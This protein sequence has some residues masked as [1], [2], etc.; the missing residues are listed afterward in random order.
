MDAIDE[1]GRSRPGLKSEH[2]RLADRLES[3]M[4]GMS[5]SRLSQI[6]GV[7]EGTVRNILSGTMPRIDN[8]EKICD[9]LGYSLWW[10][11]KGKGPEKQCDLD[12][13]LDS[14]DIGIEFTTVAQYDVEASGGHG[15]IVHTEPEIGKLAFRKAWLEKKGLTVEQLAVIRIKGNSM[16][17]TI[18]D[19][20][21]VLIDTK[22]ESF[23]DD[24]IYVLQYDGYL[25]AK[26]LQRDALTNGVLIKSDNSDYETQTITPEQ[27]DQL[28]I[29]GRVIWA[30]QEV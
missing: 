30:G 21:L 12:R 9:A 8:L 17:P 10:M 23:S 13:H 6:S 5:A 11:V 4:N 19:A 7:S 26:R 24:G 16:F 25:I 15:S 3:A 22:Q 18:R 1:H 14:D 20:A 27:L 2:G 28:Y 29:I